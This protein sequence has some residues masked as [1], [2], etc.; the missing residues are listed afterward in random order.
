MQQK[1]N[2]FI[3]FLPVVCAPLLKYLRQN[4][5]SLSDFIFLPRNSSGLKQVPVNVGKCCE[6]LNTPYSLQSQVNWFPLK[7][8]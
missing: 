3:R 5:N 7:Y 2:S 6:A 4:S 1:G 8:L